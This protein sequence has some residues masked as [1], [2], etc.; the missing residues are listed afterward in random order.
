MQISM[1]NKESFDLEEFR[2]LARELEK[3]HS[4]FDRLWS[5]GRP[6][7]TDSI[8]TAAVFFD[9]IGECIEFKINPTFWKTLSNA[10]KQFVISHECLHTILYHGFRINNLKSEELSIANQAL[11]IVVN[12]S[13][14]EKFGF[15]REEIDPENKYCWVDTVFTSN[16]PESNQYYEFYYNLLEKLKS[17]SSKNN[18]NKSSLN[19]KSDSGTSG[20]V[21]DSHDGLATFNTPEF[22]NKIKEVASEEELSSISDFVEKQIED[23]KSICKQAGC[24][25]GNTYIIANTKKVKSKKKW[26]TVIKKWAS[27]YLKDNDV[28]QWARLNRRL[29]FMA[30]DFL[31][32][33]EQETEEFENDRIQVWFFQ[34]TSGSCSG[35]IDRFFRA[36]KSLPKERFDVKMHC[37]DTRVFETTLE[38]GKLYGFGG[39]TF[40]CIENYIQSYIKKHNLKYPKAVFVITDGYGNRVYP[41]DQKVWHWFIDGDPY[42]VPPESKK[43]NLKDFE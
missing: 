17:S 39:T 28:E 37:F 41:Q 20:Q 9:K 34:D 10:Q 6:I 4:I 35:F 18:S 36:A 13:L 19:G 31:L 11:D 12:H 2:V 14:V 42:L 26:E 43:Y 38:S 29:T 22:E 30:N 33:S 25:P 3:H 24:N 16:A 32:P 23:I 21:L 1:D 40:S 27:K 7:F 8:S 15:V 5:M